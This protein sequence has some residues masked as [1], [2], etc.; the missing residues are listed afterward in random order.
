M[1]TKFPAALY[2]I[3]FFDYSVYMAQPKQ[4][5]PHVVDRVKL[6]LS[7]D[8]ARLRAEYD[9]M[10]LHPYMFYSTV[11]LK[12][13]HERKPEDPPTRSPHIMSLIEAFNQHTQVTLARLLRLE[14][15]SEVRQ[16][17]DPML[18]LE[19][20]DSVVRLTIPIFG[21]ENVTFYLNDTP[22]PMQA[23]EC[24]YLKLSDQHRI[25]HGGLEERVNLTI[26]MKPTQW[27][28]D[29]IQD[30]YAAAQSHS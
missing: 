30:S 11:M 10:G 9:A 20:P 21:G 3:G 8:A 12:L 29:L 7:Y 2:L 17:C 24:W 19:V 18:G 27:V 1:A 25:T 5:D 15:G 6:P 28:R 23:G 4:M 16:H 13:P 14:P 22:V 26:D